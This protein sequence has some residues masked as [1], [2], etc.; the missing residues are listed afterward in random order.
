MIKCVYISILS[1]LLL[2][3]AACSSSQGMYDTAFY[4]GSTAVGTGKAYCPRA[5]VPNAESAIN[6]V[7]DTPIAP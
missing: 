1:I 6:I 5:S 3:T 7:R 2:V 4:P